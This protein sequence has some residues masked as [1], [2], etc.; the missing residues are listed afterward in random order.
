M[1]GRG[2][3]LFLRIAGWLMTPLVLI[4]AAIAGAI[5]GLMI[6]PRFSSPD[7]G[8]IVTVLLSFTA[9]V[10]GLIIWIRMLREHPRLRHTL[11]MAVDGSPDTPLVQAI[12]HPDDAKPDERP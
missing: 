5:L 9:A 8:L 12:I 1:P 6:A 2:A 4:T 7:T 11:E 10:A 3:R